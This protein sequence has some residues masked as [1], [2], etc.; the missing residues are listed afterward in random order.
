MA[1]KATERLTIA[2]T[3]ERC[4][5]AA[6]DFERYPEW[7]A[8]IKEAKVLERDPEGRGT[9]V[10]YR[11]AA[12]GKS[13][14][15]TLGYDYGEAPRQLSWKLLEGDIMRR[16]D[17]SYE[18]RPVDGDPDNTDVVYQL[19]VDLVIPLPGFV[20]QRPRRTTGRPQPPRRVK[21]IDDLVSER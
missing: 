20:K 17:G 11:A 21:R 10:A 2:A 18:L 19:V 1:D 12:M 9:Q 7:A 5:E 16:L 13:T 8:D 15:Y 4:F 6:V 14:R 3:P